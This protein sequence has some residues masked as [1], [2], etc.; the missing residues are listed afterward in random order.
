MSVGP[1][2]DFKIRD[3]EMRLEEAKLERHRASVH[4]RLSAAYQA[5]QTLLPDPTE[6][7][8]LITMIARGNGI[9]GDELALLEP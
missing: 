5:V 7:E 2:H 6:R 3:L 4:Q 8:G 1:D 9:G